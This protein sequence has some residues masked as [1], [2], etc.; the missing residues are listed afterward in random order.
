MRADPGQRLQC[1]AAVERRSPAQHLVEESAQREQIRPVIERQ[2]P[3]LLRRHGAEGA[4]HALSSVREAS[5]SSRLARP[6]SRILACPSGSHHHV[7]GLEVPVD[8]PAGVGGGQAFGDLAAEADGLVEGSGPPSI[9]RDRGSPR[10]LQDDGVAFLAFDDVVDLDD[11]GMAEAGRGAG[12]AAE[13]LAGRRVVRVLGPDELDR[14]PP[15]QPLVVG[16]VDLSHSAG[17]DPLFEGVGSDRLGLLDHR[18]ASGQA[19]LGHAA[20]ETSL[21]D[22]EAFD[23]RVEVAAAPLVTRLDLLGGR[24]P[25]LC[26]FW[27]LSI[28]S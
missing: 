9:M 15:F 28:L 6:K 24:G 10:R 3:G 7:L 12:F 16:L 23:H 5:P 4:D 17:A 8:D 14:D 1:R 25:T 22:F 19:E 2:S 27:R 21:R 18:A 20:L 26:G 11:R 13:A